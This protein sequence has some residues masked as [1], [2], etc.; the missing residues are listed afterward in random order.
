MT[1]SINILFKGLSTH[2]TFL[3]S[4]GFLES[5]RL[6]HE[7]K[8][9][10]VLTFHNPKFLMSSITLHYFLLITLISLHL[11]IVAENG[12]HLVVCQSNTKQQL[13]EHLQGRTEQ[14]KGQTT[15]KSITLTSLHVRLLGVTIEQKCLPHIN[16][17]EN[18]N[19]IQTYTIVASECYYTPT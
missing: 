1:W 13:L 7:M 17:N 10:Y 8:L 16:K 6:V 14:L 19:K 2:T 4:V 12:D 3:L 5:K 18:N 9:P 15:Q 11:E